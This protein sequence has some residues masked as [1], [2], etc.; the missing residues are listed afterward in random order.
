MLSKARGQYCQEVNFII[1]N[2]ALKKLELGK[3]NCEIR[4][5]V[6]GNNN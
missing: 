1:Y 3:L 6:S 2:R 4:N 5:T